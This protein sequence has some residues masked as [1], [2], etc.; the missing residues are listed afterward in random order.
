MQLSLGHSVAW[1][2]RAMQA[3]EAGR[4]Y[5]RARELCRQVG[6]TPQLFAVLGDCGS[7]YL[8]P[9]GSPDGAGALGEECLALAQSACRP[10]TPREAHRHA[11][12]R[13]V[14]SWGNRCGPAHPLRARLLPSMRP[15]R[16]APWPCTMAMVTLDAVP[17]LL[18]PHA[19]G[20]WAIR[21]RPCTAV[22]QALALAQE[23]VAPLQPGAALYFAASLHQLPSGGGCCARTSRGCADAH[24]HRAGVSALAWVWHLPTG[25][26]ACRAGRACG[27]DRPCAKAWSPNG[28]TGAG[29]RTAAISGQ[30]AEAYGQAGQAAGGL[31]ILAEALAHVDHNGG[32][33]LRSRAASV[34]G[35]IV[36]AAGRRRRSARRKP[37]CSKPWPL[38]VANR[39]DP[40][41]YGRH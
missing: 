26:G 37:A 20:C 12:S 40:G 8:H 36:A 21:T 31:R 29:A 28:P 14:S 25:M 6:D 24:R 39:P 41:S 15:S 33:L 27:G 13:L 9:G 11:R 4:A 16:T 5:A 2:P 34:A 35:G 18:Q 22:Q 17:W 23:R 38:P 1:S 7:F 32:A 19:A 3:P 30:L 10:S